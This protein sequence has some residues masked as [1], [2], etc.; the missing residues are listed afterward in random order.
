[1]LIITLD[2]MMYMVEALRIANIIMWQSYR[3]TIVYRRGM[4]VLYVSDVFMKAFYNNNY[5]ITCVYIILCYNPVLHT[6]PVS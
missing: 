4:V 2:S 5:Y 6:S 1:M 3:H